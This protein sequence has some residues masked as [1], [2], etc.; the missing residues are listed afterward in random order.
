MKPSFF[1][2][3]TVAGSVRV[4]ICLYVLAS[5]PL[6][7]LGIDMQQ[8]AIRGAITPV[9]LPVPRPAIQYSVGAPIKNARSCIL[10]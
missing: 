1:H 2:P 7:D 3:E 9:L 10:L 8:S 5:R 6:F 4:F